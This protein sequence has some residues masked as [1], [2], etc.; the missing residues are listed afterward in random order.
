[1]LAQMIRAA[2]VAA[3][4]SAVGYAVL[5]YRNSRALKQQEKHDKAALQEWETDG[6]SNVATRPANASSQ[7][8]VM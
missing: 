1:M 8:R 6:G 5:A 4:T 7:T 3:M 2:A